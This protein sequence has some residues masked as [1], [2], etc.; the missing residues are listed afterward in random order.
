[1]NKTVFVLF[2]CITCLTNP[3]IVE[4]SA[5]SNYCKLDD[6]RALFYT[7]YYNYDLG[8]VGH[9]FRNSDFFNV[10]ESS[11]PRQ[12]V[13]LGSSTSKKWRVTNNGSSTYT[14]YA[15]W[16]KPSSEKG[17]IGNISP[18]NNGAFKLSYGQRWEL[19][20]ESFFRPKGEGQNVEVS[21]EPVIGSQQAIL[22]MWWDQGG[23]FKWDSVY[24]FH[25]DGVN[26]WLPPVLNLLVD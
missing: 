9:F 13:N 7:C 16:S 18:A 8:L 15:S 20:G 17:S 2:T 12:V 5:E 11:M 19:K 14:L 1:M 21:V 24:E 22:Y 3:M 23:K 4:G 6:S 25:Y 10:Q 26:N